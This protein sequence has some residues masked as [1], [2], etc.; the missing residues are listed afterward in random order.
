M[1]HPGL[2]LYNSTNTSEAEAYHFKR[3]STK[4][5]PPDVVLQ[6]C[7]L[8]WFESWYVRSASC[9]PKM[10]NRFVEC[11]YLLWCSVGC[12]EMFFVVIFGLRTLVESRALWME[13]QWLTA[14]FAH[15]LC[16]CVCEDISSHAFGIH[17]LSFTCR[18]G[19]IKN[20]VWIHIDSTAI[21]PNEYVELMIFTRNNN[22]WGDVEGTTH[23]DVPSVYSHRTE[24]LRHM[25][26]LH[27]HILLNCTCTHAIYCTDTCIAY[28]MIYMIDTI[29]YSNI[30]RYTNP[31]IFRLSLV[32][33][34]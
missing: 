4:V 23:I 24:V 12:L 27:L 10:I 26:Y 16:L 22:G 18:Y 15:E 30:I 6:V 1:T 9:K 8:G 2:S 13:F 31:P 19:Y 21:P 29:H 3:C 32:I 5:P 17:K 14:Q 7:F 20:F 25:H 34:L 11:S 33:Y 28:N